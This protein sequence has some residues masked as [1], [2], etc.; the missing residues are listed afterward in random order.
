MCWTM[1]IFAHEDYIKSS[2]VGMFISLIIFSVF[3]YM[4]IKKYKN[5]RKKKND[6]IYSISLNIGLLPLLYSNVF[7][8][9]YFIA[10]KPINESG[11]VYVLVLIYSP[12]FYISAF[13]PLIIYSYWIDRKKEKK[14]FCNE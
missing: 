2:Y 8:T 13:I 10:S 3:I 4:L 7:L 9:P 12:V 11:M 5:Y 1:L 14:T 6:Y